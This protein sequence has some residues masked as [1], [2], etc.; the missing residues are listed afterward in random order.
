MNAILNFREMDRHS[1]GSAGASSMRSS[2][3]DNE[4]AAPTALL[5]AHP[6]TIESSQECICKILRGYSS[7]KC[8]LVDLAA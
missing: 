6:A 1:S 3:L 7:M 4:I 2:N 5:R 8:P